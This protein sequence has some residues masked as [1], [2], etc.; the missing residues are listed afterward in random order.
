MTLDDPEWPKR[1][2]CINEKIRSSLNEDSFILSVAKCRR[3]ILVSRY[4]KYMRIFA[5]VPREGRQM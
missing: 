4:V 2:S 3:M 5:G 1:P